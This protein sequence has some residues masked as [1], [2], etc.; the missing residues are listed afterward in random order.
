[1]PNVASKD[2]WKDDVIE[3]PSHVVFRIKYKGKHVD[4]NR[5][6]SLL[7]IWVASG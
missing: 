6:V 4:F 5:E 3:C 7:E 1:M 2:E